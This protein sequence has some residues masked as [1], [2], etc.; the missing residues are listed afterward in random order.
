MRLLGKH[1]CLNYFNLCCEFAARSLLFLSPGNPHAPESFGTE[2]VSIGGQQRKFRYR[3]GS[4]GDRGVV[5]QIFRD[6]DYDIDKWKQ[7]KALHHY[8]KQ[9]PKDIP[10][11]IVDAG[12]NIGASAVYFHLSYPGSLIVAIEPEKMNCRLLHFNCDDLDV[13]VIEGAVGA[14]TGTLYVQDLGRSDWGFQVGE[15]GLYPVKVHTMNEILD[16]YI[17]VATPFILKMDIEGAEASLFSQPCP[18]L[19]NFP[20]IIIELH[21]WMAKGKALSSSFYRQIANLDFD[22]I[23]QGENTLCFNNALLRQLY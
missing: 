21:D 1:R 14:E 7:S 19:D 11:L 23:Q 6:R 15:T 9:L 12:A 2:H 20:L 22:I 5:R 3:V 18:W 16:R 8:F 17:G 4:R 13:D 10:K